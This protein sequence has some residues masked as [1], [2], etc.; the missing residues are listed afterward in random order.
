M[1][2]RF[3]GLYPAVYFRKKSFDLCLRSFSGQNGLISLEKGSKRPSRTLEDDDSAD[4]AKIASEFNK[5][6]VKSKR[7][8][9]EA[10]LS[11]AAELERLNLAIEET[12]LSG[13]SPRSK[14]RSAN[15]PAMNALSSDLD[16]SGLDGQDDSPTEGFINKKYAKKSTK[17]KV[18][19]NTSPERKSKNI[20]RKK[21]QTS[22]GINKSSNEKKPTSKNV[23]E[24]N[25]FTPD[26][27]RPVQERADRNIK[28]EM[29]ADD[30]NASSKKPNIVPKEIQSRRKEMN[31]LIEKISQSQ[32]FL[33]VNDKSIVIP[34]KGGLM[35]LDF[36]R[37][38]LKITKTSTLND[39]QFTNEFRINRCF[40]SLLR[41]E[42]DNLFR[43]NVVKINNTLAH[44][45]SMVRNGDIITVNGEMVQWVDPSLKDTR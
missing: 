13:R 25:D 41:E 23:D 20:K 36:I 16:D 15:I 11:K 1:L 42:V 12:N 4:T 37:E 6:Y 10:Y 5:L 18:N 9:E 32:E 45:G 26:I 39:L 21:E 40:P 14:L 28:S 44:R 35:E 43:R 31:S 17:S 2:K 29:D 24:W 38:P 33:D 34:T 7:L 3:T 8:N 22:K 27:P 19:A 30:P